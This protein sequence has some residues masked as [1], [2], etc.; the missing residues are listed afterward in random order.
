MKTLVFLAISLCA[1]G[2]AAGSNEEELSMEIY[3]DLGTQ[4]I[5]ANIYGHFSEHL[6]RCIY[7]GFW[8]G[9]DSK[10]PNMRPQYYAD[11]YKRYQTY[12]R[13]FSGNKLFKIA[14]G[15]YNDNYEWTEI[16]MREAASRMH[17]LSFHYYTVTGTWQNKGSAT[18][19]TEEEY[20]TTLKKP[21]ISINSLSDIPRLWTNMIRKNASD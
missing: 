10:I 14:C 12:L 5:N 15:S 13:N 3:A 17:G 20:F 19:F 4:E 7:E 11:L 18:Q 21:C 9:L 6:G 2:I 16:L 8:V 1:W